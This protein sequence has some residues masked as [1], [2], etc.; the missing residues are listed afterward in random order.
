MLTFRFE[1]DARAGTAVSAVGDRHGLTT[2]KSYI[3]S[4]RGDHHELILRHDGGDREA[5]II[6][7]LENVVDADSDHSWD[8]CY[9]MNA[10]GSTVA[11][12]TAPH[13][14][15]ELQAA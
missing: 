9:V 13:L 4:H 1:N 7:S 14:P 3:C 10:T 15:Q 6:G 8:R 11:R 5:F 2:A 12:I